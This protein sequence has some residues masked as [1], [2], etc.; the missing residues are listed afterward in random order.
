MRSVND[1]NPK[2]ISEANIVCTVTKEEDMSLFNIGCLVRKRMM[3]G[4][5]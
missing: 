5:M 4:I 2:R 3:G 1:V